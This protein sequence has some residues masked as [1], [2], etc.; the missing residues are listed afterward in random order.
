MNTEAI[1]NEKELEN[2]PSNSGVSE[3]NEL[4]DAFRSSLVTGVSVFLVFLLAL[5]RWWGLSRGAWE[6][7]DGIFVVPALLSLF[8]LTT[9]L[10]KALDPTCLSI[11]TFMKARTR[12]VLGIICSFVTVIAAAIL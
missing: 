12:F 5:I 6:W 3:F 9:A 4:P 7:N 2:P 8:F 10:L 11:N 1:K